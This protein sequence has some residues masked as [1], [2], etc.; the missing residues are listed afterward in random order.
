MRQT[1]IALACALALAVPAHAAPGDISVAAF[2]TRA[3]ALKAKGAMAL[4]SSDM[5]LLKREGEAAGEHYK[6]RLNQERAAGRP[7]SCPPRNPKVDSDEFLSFLHSY[8]ANVR[9]STSLKTAIADFMIH[10]FPCR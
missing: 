2:L 8:P 3:D 5:S 1:I 10:K 9:G 6:S 7:S 4:F